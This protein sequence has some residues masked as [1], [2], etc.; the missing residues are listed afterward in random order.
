MQKDKNVAQV[1]LHIT[2][3]TTAAKNNLKQKKRSNRKKI[4]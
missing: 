4:N 2:S 3:K 1:N